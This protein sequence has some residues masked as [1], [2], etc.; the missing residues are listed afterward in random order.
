MNQAHFWFAPDL[1]FFLTPPYQQNTFDYPFEGNPS[2]K[3]LIESLGVPHTEVGSLE[4]NGQPAG[5]EQQVQPG[6]EI[7][8]YPANTA[9]SSPPPAARFVLDN[10]LGRL[11]AYLR[12]LGF[13]ALY[14][15]DYQ[16]EELAQIADEQ[17]R[18]LLT[19]DRRL[20]MRRAVHY[21]YSPR[22]LDLYEQLTEVMKRYQLF[23]QVQPFQRCLHC[24]TPLRPVAKQAV[25]HRLKPLT[26]Q[27]FDEFHIC[28][29]CQQIYWK[30]S[31]YERMQN[32]I[33]QVQQ[34][35]SADHPSPPSQEE[36]QPH[37]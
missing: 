13:D 6:D 1:D 21:G 11:A 3:H 37:E 15:N 19:R 26:R 17:K 22:S 30:G 23:E 7:K 35:D 33:R 14:Q 27:Y 34:T 12:M 16:D 5:F 4:I 31:H 24:N 2:V 18:I 36:E 25:L 9:N 8:V 20:L 29:N 10:H 32:L 28:P